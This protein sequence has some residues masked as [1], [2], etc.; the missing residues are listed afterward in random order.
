MRHLILSIVCLCSL[1]AK[2]FTAI[3]LKTD[4]DMRFHFT[5]NNQAFYCEPAGVTTLAKLYNKK[6]LSPFCKTSLV[7]FIQKY[8]YANKQ[9]AYVLHLEQKYYIHPYEKSCFIMLNSGISF[10]EHLL[11]NG[12][13]RLEKSFNA[14]FSGSA[15]HQKLQM[16]EKRARYHK[17]GVWSDETVSN[18]FSER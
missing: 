2:D 13:A 17:R 10:S 9:Y 16:A 6:G 18:C 3:L 14:S 5:V 15:L 11:E 8:P 12:F 1:S 7:R 4:G